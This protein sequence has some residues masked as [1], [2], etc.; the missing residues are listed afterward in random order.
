MTTMSSNIKIVRKCEFCGNEFTAKT[1]Q[2]RYCSHVCNSRNYKK[3]KREEKIET[4]VKKSNEPIAY[5]AS[6][7]IKE[8]LSID[9]TA[10]LVGASRRTI[11]R[12]ISDGKLKA[13]KLGSR[14]IIK[15]K[16]I[17]NLLK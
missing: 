4:A 14:S 1:L 3:N 17:D 11:Q 15:R 16:E 6:V 5:D 2:T 7:N 12:L 10:M 13:S 9:E 8:F